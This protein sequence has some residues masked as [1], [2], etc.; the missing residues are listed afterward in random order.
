[1]V[2]NVVPVC[3]INLN[4]IM[5]LNRRNYFVYFAIKLTKAYERIVRHVRAE[6]RSKNFRFCD[7]LQLGLP[8]IGYL[9]GQELLLL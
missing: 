5:W 8:N 1:M 2:R 9:P 3:R 7:H 4:Q 6:I